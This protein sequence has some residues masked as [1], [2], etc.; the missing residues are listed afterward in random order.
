MAESHK[1][2]VEQKGSDIQQNMLD[3]FIYKKTLKQTL[4]TVVNWDKLN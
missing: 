3:D 2:N 4:K 1:H